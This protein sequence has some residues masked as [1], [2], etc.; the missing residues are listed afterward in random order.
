MDMVTLSGF[1]GAD[2]EVRF[3]SED[4]KITVLRLATHTKKSGEDVTVW[5]RVLIWG[6]AFDNM[7]SFLKKGSDLIVFGEMHPPETYKDKEGKIKVS[8]SVSAKSLVFPPTGKKEIQQATD[9]EEKVINTQTSDKES[10]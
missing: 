2:P 3:N 9:A 6:D 1:L 8:L 10:V 4:Q 7:V 5:W